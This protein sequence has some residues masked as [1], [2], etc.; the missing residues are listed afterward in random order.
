MPFRWKSWPDE[1]DKGSSC[2]WVTLIPLSLR[3]VHFYT[4]WWTFGHFDRCS[5]LWTVVSNNSFVLVFPSRVVYLRMLIC[6]LFAFHL[7][8]WSL[9]SCF[10]STLLFKMHITNP[11]GKAGIKCRKLFLNLPLKILRPFFFFFFFLHPFSLVYF[12]CSGISRI[13]K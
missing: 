13:L 10:P 2:S 8:W 5:V 1:G 4:R 3:M 9:P 12:F 7:M 11:G 6:I